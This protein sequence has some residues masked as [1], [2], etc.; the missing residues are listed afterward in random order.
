MV[1][2]SASGRHP[3]PG[4]ATVFLRCLLVQAGW[5]YRRLIGLGF[6]FSVAPL[7]RLRPDRDEA[8]VAAALARHTRPFNAHPYLAGLAV[9]AVGRLEAEGT[10]PERVERFKDA[11]RG[12]LGGLGDQLVWAAWRPLTLLLALLATAAGAPP[13]AA[14]V[15]FLGVYNAG[16]FVLRAWA[17]AVG[18]RRGAE[19]AAAL[20]AADLPRWSRRLHGA[21]ALVLG[22]LLGWIV[23]AALTGARTGV[24]ALASGAPVPHEPG[25]G[26]AAWLGL[27][28]AGLW[29]GY[30][31][32]RTILRPAA[33][34]L[35]LVLL[36][37]FLAG[38]L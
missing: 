32:G 27:F 6:G 11:V 30:R 24:A 7:L 21:G 26:S 25:V 3:G 31:R 17:L 38:A 14:V 20:R 34:V 35:L 8:G 33:A 1:R 13:W 22:L 29:I 2:V 36:V 16:H 9:G 18:W 10:P 28:A 19:V 37:L 5:S 23:A 15:G 12:A 4:L